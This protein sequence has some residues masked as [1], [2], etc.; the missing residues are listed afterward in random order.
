MNSP[1]TTFS[2]GAVVHTERL[3]DWSSMARGLRA[4]RPYLQTPGASVSA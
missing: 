2:S 4:N 3:A 1:I